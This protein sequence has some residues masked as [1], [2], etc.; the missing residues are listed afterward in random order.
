MPLNCISRLGREVQTA[1]RRLLVYGTA[2][3][4][5]KNNGP[6][7]FNGNR[8]SR[9][10]RSTRLLRKRVRVCITTVHENSSRRGKPASGGIL[11]SFSLFRVFFFGTFEAHL[12]WEESSRRWHTGQGWWPLSWHPRC[13]SVPPSL[14]S[15]SWLRS[16]SDSIESL[17]IVFRVMTEQTKLLRRRAGT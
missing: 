12:Y 4:Q 15:V 5:K 13:E 3:N 14:A 7:T 9:N 16:S 11:S 10:T 17:E 1:V 2:I 6:I 8:L